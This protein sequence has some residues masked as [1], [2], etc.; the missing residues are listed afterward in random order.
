M[1][2]TS[3]SA[4]VS[5]HVAWAD[6]A[7]KLLVCSEAPDISLEGVN[8]RGHAVE[9]SE[10][11]KNS[12]Y[13]LEAH[14]AVAALDAH[15]RLTI[16]AGSVGQL[17]LGQAAQLAPRLH[18]AADVAQRAPHGQRGRRGWCGRHNV[19]FRGHYTA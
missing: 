19:P 13:D 15:Q 9:H 17:V 11:V 8:R 10:T 5:P 7:W 14:T 2:S 4:I 12:Q 1:T 16:D 3:R 6:T 18:V